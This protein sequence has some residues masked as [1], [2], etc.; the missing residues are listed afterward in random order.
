LVRLRLPVAPFWGRKPDRT[1]PSN[2]NS[3]QSG[4]VLWPD[5]HL[6]II[7]VVVEYLIILNSLYNIVKAIGRDSEV[8]SEDVWMVNLV[9]MKQEIK[10]IAIFWNTFTSLEI[11]L[12]V[13]ITEPMTCKRVSL[14]VGGSS[15]D[16]D[17][18]EE[19]SDPAEEGLE[20]FEED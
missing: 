3:D 2:T 1:G 6:S 8:R 16:D 7:R 10:L 19:D 14:A 13:E 18:E 5:R 12:A 15:S 11:V 17:S 4:T 9:V 20:E